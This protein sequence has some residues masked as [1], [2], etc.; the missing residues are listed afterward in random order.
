MSAVAA[1]AGQAV[2]KVAADGVSTERLRGTSTGVDVA[3]VQVYNQPITA[4]HILNLSTIEELLLQAISTWSTENLHGTWRH[5]VTLT[6]SISRRSFCIFF[7]EIQKPINVNADRWAS[8]DDDLTLRFHHNI[9]SHVTKTDSANRLEDANEW[10]QWQTLEEASTHKSA[11]THASNVLWWLTTLTFDLLTPK[12]M[13]FPESSWSKSV[14]SLVIL[15]ASVVDIC[16]VTDT[17]MNG[18]K[19]PTSATGAGL[20]G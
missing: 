9:M 18:G 14:S 1:E 8:M 15:A 19:N 6:I 7:I 13:G 20:P 11:K 3:L 12:S 10:L 4:L 17:R 16:H 5:L 2:T